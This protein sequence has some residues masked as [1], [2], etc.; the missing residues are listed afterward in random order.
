MASTKSPNKLGKPRKKGD[1]IKK[2]YKSHKEDARELCEK[3]SSTPAYKSGSQFCIRA[4]SNECPLVCRKQWQGYWVVMGAKPSSTCL[5]F[6][7]RCHCQHA[8]STLCACTRF[9]FYF[10]FLHLYLFSE[11][12]NRI[13]C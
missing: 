1:G 13:V 3:F 7:R 8:S 11:S 4:C 2:C 5:E 9:G 12:E 10:I 6:F